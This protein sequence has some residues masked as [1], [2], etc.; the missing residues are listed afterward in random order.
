M[1]MQMMII[2]V[3]LHNRQKI[4]KGI[5]GEDI[6]MMMSDQVSIIMRKLINFANEKKN[7]KCAWRKI[8]ILE[9]TN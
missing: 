6:F 9:K 3:K 5:Y 8:F 2:S 7:K 4:I 1:K